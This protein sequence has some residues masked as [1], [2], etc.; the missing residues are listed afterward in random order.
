M[1][2]RILFIVL[3]YAV[4]VWSQE[5]HLI[6]GV[7][8]SNQ[9]KLSGVHVLNLSRQEGGITDEYGRYQLIAA[10][11]DTLSFSAIQYV[12]KKI[13]ITRKEL[14]EERLDVLLRE[15][16]NELDPVLLSDQKLSGQL[17]ED[18][19]NIKTYE[20]YFPLWNAEEVIRAM[21][22]VKDDAQSPVKNQVF[23]DG[24]V[25]TPLNF[26]AIGKLVAGFVKK[27]KKK[28]KRPK[29]FIPLSAIY[30][31]QFVI[32]K[33]G[34]PEGEYESFVS[35]I[36]SQPG[37]QEVFRHPDQLIVLEYCI[38]MAAHYRKQ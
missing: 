8:M 1:K 35:Y 15:N 26:I 10:A 38:K 7:V 18:A 21:P 37:T 36:H 28:K 13:K 2:K 30:D 9:Q 22:V 25:A 32:H 27:K 3:L 34:I 29:K 12:T 33:I 6:Q 16:V 24:T 4:Q 14:M 19:K 31:K 11:G 23:S 20:Q 17:E 5:Q